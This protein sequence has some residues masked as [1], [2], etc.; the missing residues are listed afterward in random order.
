MC[1]HCNH[2][3]LLRD[4]AEMIESE[5]YDYAEDTLVG[6]AKWVED[7]QHCT[8]KQES[9]VANIKSKPSREFEDEYD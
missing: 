8:E 1:D 2:E 6:I 5:R 3:D 7:N 9:A 4:I